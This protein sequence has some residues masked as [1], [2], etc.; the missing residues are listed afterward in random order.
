MHVLVAIT[1]AQGVILIVPREKRVG[2]SLYSSYTSIGS[3]CLDKPGRKQMEEGY[4]S[5]TMIPLKVSLK[6]LQDIE[7]NV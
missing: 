6:A 4:L 7:A 3:Y 5:W 2:I 1:Y